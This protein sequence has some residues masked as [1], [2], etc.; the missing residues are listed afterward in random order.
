[1]RVSGGKRGGEQKLRK[2]K[3]REKEQIKKMTD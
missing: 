1:M 2:E 3:F